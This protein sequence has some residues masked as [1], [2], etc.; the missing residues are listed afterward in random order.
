MYAFKSDWWQ[1]DG[2]KVIKIGNLENNSINLTTCACVSEDKIY[3]AQ[4]FRVITGDLLIAMTGATAGKLAIIPKTNEFLFVNQRVGKFLLGN[5]PISKL[6]FIYCNLMQKEVLQDIISGGDG[7]S[8]QAN[9][10]PDN[11]MQTTIYYPDKNI[12]DY[13]NNICKPLFEVIAYNHY[14]IQALSRLRDTLLPNLMS[15]DSSD[16]L[17]FI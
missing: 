6:S 2:V 7:S 4:N 1:S 8:A 15:G 3:K 5:D 12:I 14:K 16:K 9:I 10:S 17:S 11:I 13:F